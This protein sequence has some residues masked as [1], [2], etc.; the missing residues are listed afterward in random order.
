[1]E[2]RRREV[3]DQIR[4]NQQELQEME[5]HLESMKINVAELPTIGK[6]KVTC[7]NCH[8]R[9][10][11]N[12]QLQ[13]CALENTYCGLKDKHPEYFT[14]MNKVKSA[15]N[16]RK[17]VLKQLNSELEGINNFQS[18]SEYNFIK[19]LTPRMMK[20]N[21]EYKSNRPKLLRDIRILRKYFSCKIPEETTNDAEQ[22]RI[23]LGKA[24]STLE[25]DVGDVGLIG[26]E[27][28]EKKLASGN[29]VSFNVNMNLT[30]VKNKNTKVTQKQS[31][32]A[33][34]N[35]T[36][37]VAIKPNQTEKQMSKR[38]GKKKRKHKKKSRKY[39]P[40]SS[41]STESS[42]SSSDELSSNRQTR[43][44]RRRYKS[45]RYLDY[46]HKNEH[47]AMPMD[48]FHH[49]TSQLQPGMSPKLINPSFGYSQQTYD[50]NSRMP[51]HSHMPMAMT[52]PQQPTPMH[53]LPN[54]YLYANSVQQ[55]LQKNQ[56]LHLNNVPG[57]NVVQADSMAGIGTV[58]E[59]DRNV[60][61]TCTSDNEGLD[62]LSSAVDYVK[63]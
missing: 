35:G 17:D 18:Q 53:M 32:N 34:L 41:E 23:A 7:S 44:R 52:M 2:N 62:L 15:V 33:E 22:L 38:R 54:N 36:K 6:Q 8:H 59:H 43:H 27:E 37:P 3:E 60:V 1:M 11:R 28:Y 21:I 4:E 29:A 39:G 16:K 24:K 9:G 5:V 26:I 57:T 48:N 63:K 13:P 47:F 40:S 50:V 56:Q 19:S 31:M 46:D 49:T 58:I 51:M 61:E 12:S 25:R 14:E 30:P 45:K 10:H 42:S 55:D 20:V